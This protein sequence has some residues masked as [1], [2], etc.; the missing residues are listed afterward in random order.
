[1]TIRTILRR[2]MAALGLAATTMAAPAAAQTARPALWKVSDPDTTIYLFGTIH[3]LP[4]GTDWKSAEVDRAIG[5]SSE[6]VVETIIDE[7]NPAAILGDL[8]KL[9]VS[10][11]LPPLIERVPPAKRDRLKQLI[12][13]TGAPENAFDAFETWTASLMLLGP[14]MKD[15]GLDSK[16]GVESNLKAS[17]EVAGKK[18]GQLETN[19]EQFGFFD[20]LPEEAQRTFLEGILDD[21]GQSKKTLE[22][23]ISAWSSGDVVA[24]GKAFNEEMNDEPALKA[25]LLDQ[26]NANWTRW[27]A[28]R[29]Q[30][31]GTVLVAVGAGH[32][33]GDTSVVRMLEQRGLKVTRLQ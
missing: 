24:I 2:A 15:Y 23:M 20:K 31:P 14:Q 12:A 33:A 17:F 19:A 32:L 1:M 26:R 28:G 16:S 30:Q 13:K 8:M 4:K 27:I 7:K 3:L 10:P 9:G 5:A 25:A 11:G 22:S 21:Q 29:L 18:I 6:L